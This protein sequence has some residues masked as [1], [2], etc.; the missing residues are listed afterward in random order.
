MGSR[1]IRG[2]S[3]RFHAGAARPVGLLEVGSG[4]DTATLY[5]VG[6]EE[7]CAG[8]VGSADRDNSTCKKS[9][10]LEL[11]RY[12]NSGLIYHSPEQL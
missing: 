5:K 4:F 3:V 1:E 7:C 11:N 12:A 9:A 6:P 8:V 2:V 10:L